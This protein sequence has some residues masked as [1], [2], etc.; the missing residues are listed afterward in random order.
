[1]LKLRHL[2][3][4]EEIKIRKE[5]KI[6]TKERKQIEAVL[7]SDRRLI[8]LI[9]KELQADA[10]K[11][12][13]AR[14]SPLKKRREAQALKETEIIPVEPMTVVLSKRGWVRS[15]KGHDIDPASLNYKAGDGFK[16]A[17]VG[18]SNQQAVFLDSTGRC[19]AL[20]IH[21]LPSA[22]GQ[23]EPLS[24]RMNIADGA[25]IEAVLVASDAQLLLMAGRNGYGFLGKFSEFVSKN[26]NGK[27]VITLPAD[28]MP[29]TPLPV[30]HPD[31]DQVVAISSEGH[32]LMFAVQQLPQQSRGKGNQIIRMPTSRTQTEP[33][34]LKFLAIR[35]RD[36]IIKIHCGKRHLTLKPGHF[37]AYMGERGR[38]GKKLPRG[39]QNV[40]RL[41]VI[42]A[43]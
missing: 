40:T 5:Q 1:E 22:R 18:R 26:R 30:L 12:G 6:L 20:P 19:Y 34:C 15:A 14:R 21:T 2:A 13:D 11:Y 17:A 9:R 28:V 32:M 10:E 4:L 23:G 24:G 39:F 16:M 38:Q 36:T 42:A 43:S 35:P 27:Q 37:E 29:M 33:G 3:R 41:E 31:T 25:T 8:T 7:N